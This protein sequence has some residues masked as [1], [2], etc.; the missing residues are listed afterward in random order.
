MPRSTK[1]WRSGARQKR[2]GGSTAAG[3]DC[4][5]DNAISRA[6]SRL[7]AGRVGASAGRR[8][9]HPSYTKGRPPASPASRAGAPVRIPGAPLSQPTRQRCRRAA[10]PLRR[11]RRDRDARVTAAWSLQCVSG[12]HWTRTVGRDRPELMNATRAAQGAAGAAA[13]DMVRRLV[14]GSVLHLSAQLFLTLCTYVV[15]VVLARSLGPA[16][17][18][19][20]GIVYSL[21]MTT[22]FV[23]RFGIPQASGK[24]MA[25][26]PAQHDRI[27]ASGLTIRS[28]PISCCSRACGSR[29][30]RS[31][32][33]SEFRRA[34]GCSGSPS[35]TS[36]SMAR[37]SCSG[38]S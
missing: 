27:A 31:P 8:G 12:R 9:A 32:R 10:F 30:R 34:P 21:L 20:Y 36:R 18:G 14:Q 7:R 11:W 15:A 28:R 4:V 23:G 1:V 26:L 13:P 3:V 29:R 38:T 33:S 17:F 2:Q 16:A 19:T 37:S 35:G 22:E 6:R 24:L 25:E 5:E